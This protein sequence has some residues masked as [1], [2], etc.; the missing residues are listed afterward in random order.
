MKIILLFDSDRLDNCYREYE[1]Q[2]EIEGI[3]GKMRDK[4]VTITFCHPDHGEI[5]E[6]KVVDRKQVLR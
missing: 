4:L 3:D 5:M 6:M 1:L 2:D